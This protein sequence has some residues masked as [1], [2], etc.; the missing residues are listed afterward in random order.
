MEKYK[1]FFVDKIEDFLTIDGEEFRHAVNVLRIRE[2]DKIILLDNTEYEY[3]AE[4]TKIEK[5]SMQVKVL[6]KEKNYLESKNDILLIAGYLKGDKTELVVQ[7]AVEL[8]VKDIVVFSSKFSSAFLNDNK[9]E[10]LNKVSQE[11]SKQCGRSIYPKVSY[12]PFEEA[13]KY[14]KDYKNKLFACEFANENQ[15][16]FSSLNGNTAVVVGSEGGF[17][18]DEFVFATKEGFSTVSLGKRILR[19]DTAS[20]VLVGIV[21]KMLGD[22]EWKL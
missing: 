14:A 9:L 7:T 5:K 13:I 20:I 2:N 4:V 19:A 21:A 12:L 1:R 16:D 3:L 10:R 18:E 17:S 6:S 8:G 22:L 11:A 15:V